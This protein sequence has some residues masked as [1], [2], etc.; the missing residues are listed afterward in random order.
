MVVP[1]FGDGLGNIWFQWRCLMPYSFN[2]GLLHCSLFN[3]WT[4]TLLCW[5]LAP[6][7]LLQTTSYLSNPDASIVMLISLF[8]PWCPLGATCNTHLFWN[9]KK[10][11]QVTVNG[12]FLFCQID[13]KL[14]LY[15]LYSPFFLPYI[16]YLGGNCGTQ[17]YYNMNIFRIE[18]LQ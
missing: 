9:V 2:H 6:N 15:Y 13:Q 5:S 4:P 11:S 8:F 17:H 12:S 1:P 10:T 7:R 3:S 16:R 18:I 14:W